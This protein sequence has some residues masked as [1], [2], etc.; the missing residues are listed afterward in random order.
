MGDK[1]MFCINCS[2]ITH[3]SKDCI[4]P[5]NSYGI[6]CIKLDDLLGITPYMIEKYLINK[7]IDFDEYNFS[8]LKN[9]SI[10]DLYKNKIKFLLVQ[11]KHS[12]SY[13]D[14]IRGKYNDDDIEEIKSLLN[15]TTKKEIDDILNNNF[16][17]LWNNLWDKTSKN[18][19]Y[20]KEFEES[21]IKFNKIKK[22]NLNDIID[23][24]NLYE[25]PEWGFP[26][27]RKDK[28]EKNIDCAIREFE[29]ETG[30]SPDKY[31]I[32]NRLSTVEEIVIC[33]QN[34]TYKLVYYLA[35]IKQ[36]IELNNNK[37]QTLE[38]SDLKWL[39]FE[40]VIPKIR[41]YFK[42]KISMIYQVYFLF[43]NL[44]ENIK[45]SLTP[46]KIELNTT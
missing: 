13:V 40:N 34:K 19:C 37:Y 16:D 17:Y 27:G 4:A 36:D 38:I 22:Y 43:L 2:K 33:N 15:L 39:S 12:F 44:I 41:P 9:L 8:N 5:I 42:D 7:V 46:I 20:Q 14:F 23:F 18:K 6:I 30:I 1:K 24:K 28:N 3:T 26:K 45:S 10:I 31:I 29:E 25:T 21:K 35:I 11:R 32:F